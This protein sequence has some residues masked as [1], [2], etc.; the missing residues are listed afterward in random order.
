MTAIF[1]ASFTTCHFEGEFGSFFAAMASQSAELVMGG[2]LQFMLPLRSMMN[3]MFAGTSEAVFPA[4]AHPAK[5]EVTLEPRLKMGID[6]SVAVGAAAGAPPWGG[7]V[8]VPVGAAEGPLA[9]L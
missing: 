2:R 1:S 6:V 5:F 3:R 9:P 8:V 4:V 7:G